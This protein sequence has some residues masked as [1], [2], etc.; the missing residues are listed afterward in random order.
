MIMHWP[1]LVM[2]A[3]IAMS[4]GISLSRY[5]Q[6]KKRDKYDVIDVL[7]APAITIVI[8]YYGGFW[9]GH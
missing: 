1:Q 6:E 3:M 8:L 5:G 9:T 2:A 7:I 4:V